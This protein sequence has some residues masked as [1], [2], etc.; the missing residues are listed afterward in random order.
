MDE[1]DL[2]ELE[3]GCWINVINPTPEELEAL[4]EA[5][6]IQMD[7]LTAPMDEEEKSRT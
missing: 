5:T 2:S 3:A 6:H 4:A 1:L 7:Y